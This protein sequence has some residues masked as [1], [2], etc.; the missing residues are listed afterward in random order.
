[1]A[2]MMKETKDAK[3]R[4]IA[5][6]LNQ[7]IMKWHGGWTREFTAPK[8][9]AVHPKGLIILESSQPIRDPPSAVSSL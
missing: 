5:I 3:L 8:T 7:I 4:T 9:E 1:M 2:L 6:V